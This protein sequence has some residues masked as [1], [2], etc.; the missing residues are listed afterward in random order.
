M[1]MY[2]KMDDNKKEKLPTDIII[3]SFRGDLTNLQKTELSDWLSQEGN[4][5]KYDALKRVWDSTVSNAGEIKSQKAYCRLRRKISNVWKKFAA[6][7][8]VA[9]VAAIGFTLYNIYDT[10]TESVLTQTYTCVTGKSSVALPDGSTV[11]LHNG[12]TLS[13]DNSF[14]KTNRVVMLEGEAYFDVAKDTENTFV[15]KVDDINVAVH[16]TTFNVLEDKEYVTVSLVEG[17]VDVLIDA[18]SQCTLTPGYSAIY[19]KETGSLIDRK[20][21]VTFAACWAQDRL[22]FTQASLGEVC[23]YLSKWYGVDIVVPDGLK[24]SC[25]YTF[26]IREEPIDQILDIMSR[27]NPM[28]YLYTNDQRILISE[29]H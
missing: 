11:V 18:T 10:R 25:S 23:R 22:T 7:A 29:I 6:A 9:A 28:K 17:S 13:Y 16:G 26:T 3:A 4:Q 14:S 21:D 8:T 20:D 1:K 5:A 12:A 15:V 19:N 2:A 27:I 24:T